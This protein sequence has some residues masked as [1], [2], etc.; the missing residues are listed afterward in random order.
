MK[1]ESLILIK[2]VIDTWRNQKSFTYQT[3]EVFARKSPIKDGEYMLKFQNTLKGFYCKGKEIA[4]TTTSISFHTT[5]L[6]NSPLSAN[7]NSDK[8]RLEKLFDELDKDFYRLVDEK[9][10]ECD[11]TPFTSDPLFF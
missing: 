6:S 8:Y 3:K 7:V 2:G 11:E 4:I 10:S 5:T 9:L 1:D